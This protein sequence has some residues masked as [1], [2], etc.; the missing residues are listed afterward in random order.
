MWTFCKT[1]YGAHKLDCSQG[2]RTRE[3]MCEPTDPKLIALY[4]FPLIFSFYLFFCFI[5]LHPQCAVYT[6]REENRGRREREL[7]KHTN[8]QTNTHFWGDRKY[9]GIGRRGKRLFQNCIYKFSEN[10]KTFL[11]PSLPHSF[12]YLDKQSGKLV[13][14]L[15]H[16]NTRKRICFSPSFIRTIQSLLW[17]IKSEIVLEGAHK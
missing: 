5:L 1:S 4:S 3:K 12:A 2:E 10:Q 9:T 8:K 6:P 13:S 17:W 16:R 7:D 14:N 11:S 15:T